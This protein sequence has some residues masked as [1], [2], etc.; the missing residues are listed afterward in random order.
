MKHTFHIPHLPKLGTLTDVRRR[1]LS[2][3]LTAVLLGVLIVI[4]S[5]SFTDLTEVV[6]R[7]SRANAFS[8]IQILK[9]TNGD[10]QDEIVGLE[11]ELEKTNNQEKALEG[12]NQ[13]IDKYKILS[14]QVDIS[15][16]GVDLKI[17]SAVKAIWLTDI[18]NELFS[19]GAEAVSVNGIRLTD[20]NAG[21][22]TIPNGQ[23]VLNGSILKTPFEFTAIGDKKTLAD[24]LSQPGGILQ[25]LQQSFGT[26]DYTLDQ[27]D[28]VK[29]G[30]V[31]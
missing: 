15:G 26:V 19:A 25:R 18:V 28:L 6:G 3:L 4:Q 30:K 11:R 1:Q 23:I 20:S 8:E 2:I 7:D 16:P 22:D 31:I 29:M 17:N 5:R 13:E 24:S 27:V 12:V 14:G 10:L 9:K 21:F